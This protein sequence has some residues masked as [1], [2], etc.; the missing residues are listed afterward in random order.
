MPQG[1]LELVQA[2]A[3][4]GPVLGPDWVGLRGSEGSE[5]SEDSEDLED[6]EDSVEDSVV[7]SVEGL[8][9]VFWADLD[10]GSVEGLALGCWEDLVPG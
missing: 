4:E 9:M 5:D 6:L 1:V 3:E 7:G 10:P 8:E 2:L